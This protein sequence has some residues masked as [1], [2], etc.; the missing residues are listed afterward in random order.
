MVLDIAERELRLEVD[1]VIR[2]APSFADNETITKVHLCS[3]MTPV[4]SIFPFLGTCL[5]VLFFFALFM[6][7]YNG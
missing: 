4:S 5:V 6:Y 1:V 7:T 2:V 3:K